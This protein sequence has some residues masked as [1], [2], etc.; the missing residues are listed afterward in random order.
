VWFAVALHYAIELT[1]GALVTLKL[2]DA[3]HLEPAVWAGARV[4][5]ALY[6]WV[7]AAWSIASALIGTLA[8]RL[9]AAVM[10]GYQ[11][12]PALALGLV[13][14]WALPS[15]RDFVARAEDPVSAQVSDRPAL[16]AL[17]WMVQ[18]VCGFFASH[19]ALGA[20]WGKASR[21]RKDV[22]LGGWVG[23]ALAS[24]ALAVLGL[25]IVAGA[26]GRAVIAGG[27]PAVI[28]D[29]RRFTIK[30]VLSQ[31]V[32]GIA[33][34]LALFT[35][36][37]SLLGP[38]CFTPFLFARFSQ[39]LLPRAPRWALTLIAALLTWPLLVLRLPE[40][41]DMVFTLLG[42]LTAPLLALVAAERLRGRGRR[43]EARAGANLAALVAWLF[44]AIVGLF[45]LMGPRAGFARAELFLPAVLYAY[46]AAVGVYLVATRLGLD[47][48]KPP[49]SA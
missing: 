24:T 45:P 14:V 20:D 21:D 30:S 43:F 4:P 22:E 26:S 31:D 3:R 11:A 2:L 44:G 8:F 23:I 29:W 13:T 10:A 7:A 18:L 48:R 39:G 28:G 1:F 40:R 19:A 16:Y 9:V 49:A 17:F 36:A 47:T 12:F 32:G 6:L 33:G 34:A 37:F 46:V 15:A 42:G 27:T 5:G 38:A 41:L 25:L 35:L